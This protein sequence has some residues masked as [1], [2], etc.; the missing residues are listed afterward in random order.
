MNHGNKK[1]TQNSIDNSILSNKDIAKNQLEQ[2]ETS[3]RK[4]Y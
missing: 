4:Y 3:I 1:L 2:I